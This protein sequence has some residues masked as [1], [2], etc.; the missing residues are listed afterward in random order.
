MRRLGDYL[1]EMR[2]R[3]LLDRE[4]ERLLAGAPMENRD[5]ALLSPLVEGLRSSADHLP[6]EAQVRIVAA[7]AATVVL[8][9]SQ[10]LTDPEVSHR[11]RQMVGL[12]PRLAA[13]ILAVLM[14]PAMTGVAL[15][16]VEP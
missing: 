1:G 3:S 4:I 9:R 10:H 2:T 13:V 15:A 11:R 7:R 6:S 12:S 5:L 8:E 16:A 14:V